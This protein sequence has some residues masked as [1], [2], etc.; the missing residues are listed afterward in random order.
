MQKQHRPTIEARRIF[1]ELVDVRNIRLASGAT[2]DF[3]GL[4]YSVLSVL[5]I[6][7]IQEQQVQIESLKLEMHEQKKNLELR[8]RFERL[9]K[10]LTERNK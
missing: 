5:A 6:K 10:M 8:V 1:P 7:A 4:D 3:H 2:M 9:E